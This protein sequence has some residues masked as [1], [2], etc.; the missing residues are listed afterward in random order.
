MQQSR[1]VADVV[2]IDFNI[3]IFASERHHDMIDKNRE[4][5]D[6]QAKAKLA[7]IIVFDLDGTL[8]D[9]DTANTFSYKAAAMHVL[10]CQ[11]D[12]LDSNQPTRMTRETLIKTIPKIND[13][14]LSRII[15]RKERIYHKYLSKTILNVQLSN[16]I[17]HSRRKELILATNS[18]RARAEMLFVASRTG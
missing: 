15:Y 1:Y 9:S 4:S 3:T 14:Q 10:S 18:H 8:V 12:E 11:A 13:E 7:D 6:W 17:E 2:Y 16:I 5:K